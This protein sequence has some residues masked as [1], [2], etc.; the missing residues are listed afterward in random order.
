VI[1]PAISSLIPVG[2]MLI[3]NGMN[4]GALA[5]DRFR[6]ELESHVGQI[7]A[8]LALGADA[9][10][11]VTPYAH[12]AVRASLIPRIDSLRSLGI[13]WIPGLMA[14]MILAGEDPVYAAIYQ[15]VVIAMIFAASGLTSIA[16]VLLIRSRVFTPAQQLVVRPGVGEEE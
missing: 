3:A 8:A 11:T 14:G 6:S 4:S 7:E 13:V 1:D 15:F 5:L 9:R 12:A 2:S 16:S 10:D